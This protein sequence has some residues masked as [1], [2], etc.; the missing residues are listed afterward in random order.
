MSWDGV[1]D[2]IGGDE[3]EGADG[4]VLGTGEVPGVGFKLLEPRLDLGSSEGHCRGGLVGLMVWF[5][6]MVGWLDG[7]MDER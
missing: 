1:P 4:I 3:C 2:S 7:W 5:A 6:D